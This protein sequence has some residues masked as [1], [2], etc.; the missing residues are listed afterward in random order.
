MP[1]KCEQCNKM[2]SNL[3]NMNRHIR[4][5]HKMK[6]AS[7]NTSVW[8][9]K[10]LEDDCNKSFPR[11]NALITHLTEEHN[12]T[13][14]YTEISL[15]DMDEFQSWKSSI[16]KETKCSYIFKSKINSA[17]G[18]T[19]YYNCNRSFAGKGPR[20]KNKQYKRLLKSKGSCK[21]SSYCTS[22]IKVTKKGGSDILIQWQKTH[23]GHTFDLKHIRLSIQDREEVALKLISGVTSEKILEEIQNGL[24]KELKRL[25]LL[26]RK[27]IW[28]IKERFN[29]KDSD[30]ERLVNDAISVDLS[31]QE[32]ST[33]DSE[34]NP[35]LLLYIFE[36]HIEALAL[37][38]NIETYEKYWKIFQ[39]SGDFYTVIKLSDSKCC[40]EYCPACNICKHMYSCTCQDFEETIICKHVHYI[41]C[42]TVNSIGENVDN[43]NDVKENNV[44]VTSIPQSNKSD[45]QNLK[46]NKMIN[47]VCYKLQQ[48]EFETLNDEVIQQI[49]YHLKMLNKLIILPKYNE[50]Q[51]LQNNNVIIEPQLRFSST[52]RKRKNVKRKNTYERST[53]INNVLN[54]QTNLCV[55]T[56]P[57]YDHM[58]YE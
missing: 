48:C 7:D 37:N 47:K 42:N 55:S 8:K 35:E 54:N 36:R 33:N 3:Y 9:C 26:T 31:V 14:D 18:F 51:I 50:K 39:E 19:M 52:K 45:A 17:V 46:L 53:T 40:E 32:Y 43:Y 10:C 15:K 22:Q 41:H 24:E 16:E 4:K 44:G 58:Y 28:N 20:D 27:D 25:D 2:F 13:F 30:G 23:Y 12:K 49:A 34:D 5:V 57:I 11:N 21:M 56:S 1:V 29:I 6:P 38:Y